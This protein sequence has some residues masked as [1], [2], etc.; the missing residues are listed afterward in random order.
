[1]VSVF[2]TRA[3]ATGPA[4]PGIAGQNLASSLTKPTAF[5]SVTCLKIIF[6]RPLE[7]LIYT[8]PYIGEARRQKIL[9]VV[10]VILYGQMVTVYICAVQSVAVTVKAT[11]VK[12]FS[13]FQKNGTK[14]TVDQRY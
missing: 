4:G 3:I 5:T 8:R 13:P 11:L 9:K 2:Y 14:E 1:M 7:E 6:N 10:S 12:G